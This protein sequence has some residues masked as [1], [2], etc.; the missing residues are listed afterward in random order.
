[1]APPAYTSGS[2]S[3]KAGGCKP[4]FAGSIPAPESVYLWSNGRTALSK[5]V[6]WGFESSRVC[7]FH[8]IF[9]IELCGF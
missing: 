2:S 7:Q 5:S 4:S 9:I 8:R 6:R 3:G 1:M